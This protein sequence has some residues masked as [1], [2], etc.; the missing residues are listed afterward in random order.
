[1]DCLIEILMVEDSEDDA[2]LLLDELKRRKYTP[3][4]QRVQTEE[5]FLAALKRRTWDAVICDYVLPQFS[6]VKALK[7]FREQ[8]MDI[9]FIVVSGAFG[10]EKAVDMMK[11]GASDYI[12][13]SN[14]SR[15]VPALERE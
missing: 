2:L 15:L 1:M 11:A 10:E 14:L 12:L 13:K 9:P 7:L 3:L 5:E 4:C 8:G 6:G